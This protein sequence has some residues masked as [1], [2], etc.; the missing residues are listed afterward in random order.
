MLAAAMVATVAES[1]VR[2][3]T[4]SASRPKIRP[5]AG[6]AAKPTAKTARPASTSA[7]WLPPAKNWEAKYG[8]NTA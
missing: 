8:T 3:P 4:R 6:R 5:P 1:A 2:R 7:T